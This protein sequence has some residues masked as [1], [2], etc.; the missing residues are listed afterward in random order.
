MSG[1]LIRA[2]SNSGGGADGLY[3]LGAGGGQGA[4]SGGAGGA[5][6]GG[7][8]LICASI[9]GNDGAYNGVID[10]SGGYGLPGAAD[11][12]GAGGGG[13]GGAVILSSQAKVKSWPAVH[14]AGG[15]GALAS[16]P[17]ALATGGSCTARPKIALGVASGT[18]SSCTVAQPG[19]GCGAGT[20]VVWN[21]V[22]GGGT[23]GTITA[24]WSGGALQ[25]CQAQGGAGYTAATYATAGAGGDGGNGW[26][27]KFQGW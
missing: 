11:G 3:L 12:T 24:T 26:N 18:L 9:S 25:S 15:P 22:G 8:V 4:N 17:Q 1:S 23:G 5:G 19:A 2:F 20:G 27:A 14:A 16:V 13:G 10:A 7:V 6:G 21:I